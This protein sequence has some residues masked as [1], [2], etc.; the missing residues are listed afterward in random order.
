MG[1][2]HE[3]RS[4]RCYAFFIDREQAGTTFTI[5]E[6]SVATGWKP[7]TIVTYFNKK[8]RQL[9][10]RGELG[11]RVSG[12]GAFSENEFV[13]LMS[14]NDDVNADPRRPDLAPNVEAL[15]RK[16]RESALLAL[17]VYNNPTTVFRTEGFAVLMVVAWTALFHA[18]FES[19]GTSYFYV[20]DD[21][22]PR[23]VDGD[24][25]AWELAKCTEVYWPG[26]QNATKRNLDFFVRLRN[27]IEHRYV[28]AIDPHVAGE[29]QA[30]IL[31]FDSMLV[32]EFGNYFAIRDAIAIPL[33]TSSVRV[34]SQTEALRKLQAQHFDEV[35]QFIDTY[36]GTLPD[37]IYDDQAYAFRV[38]LMPKTGNH[39]NSSDLAIEF[40]RAS[41]AERASLQ[42]QIVAIKDRQVSVANAN[43]RKA[44]EVVRDVASRL[45]LPFNM[46]HH[47]RASVRYAARKPGK[48]DATG[49]DPRYCIPDPLH[50]DYGWTD[51]WV[52]LLVSKLT[53]PDEYAAVTQPK[54]IG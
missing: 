36:R 45:K 25:K 47:F 18:I 29:C 23:I 8:L 1:K 30:L 31:N 20:N 2:H 46:T 10:H 53:N 9:V 35:K 6:L 19:N 52:E 38:F 3:T 34:A 39:R 28:P 17:Q 48:F 22:S 40:V 37:S 4:R 43:L 26:E 21:G 14:Q 12:V 49:C 44:K 42:S 54:S 27:K 51:A 32:E 33:Q 13:R 5:E 24:E 11:Y 50:R 15:V 7:R 41:D 16:A